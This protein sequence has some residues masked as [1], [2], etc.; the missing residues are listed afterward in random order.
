[1]KHS[2][3]NSPKAISETSEKVDPDKS[4]EETEDE[5]PDDEAWVPEIVS[6]VE[7][8]VD[9]SHAEVEEDDA[10]HGGAKHGDEVV[11]SDLSLVRDILEGVV[12]LHYGKGRI[13]LIRPDKTLYRWVGSSLDF[14]GVATP[15]ILCQ[16]SQLS[17]CHTEPAR[18]K[19]RPLGL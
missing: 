15:S 5:R 16:G 7:A 13:N 14:R 2:R 3:D 12:A 6:R 9:H 4:D 1:M 18:N 11:D 10:V 8:E 19:E 17:F